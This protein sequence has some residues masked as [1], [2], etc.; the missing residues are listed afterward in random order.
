[1]GLRHRM[2]FVLVARRTGG[3]IVAGL[4]YSTKRRFFWQ[5]RERSAG[6]HFLPSPTATRRAERR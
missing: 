5:M 4:R 6:A 3:S 2:S 1:M